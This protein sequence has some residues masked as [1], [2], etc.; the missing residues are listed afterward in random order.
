MKKKINTTTTTTQTTEELAKRAEILYFYDSRMSNPNGD[1]NENKP[2]FDE[3]TQKIYVTEFRLK[4][5]IR[6]YLNEIMGRK[7]LLRQEL[8]ED[9][10]RELGEQSLKMLDKLAAPYIYEVDGKGGKDKKKIKKIK[11]DEL[12]ADHIDIKLFGILFAVGEVQF[13]QVGPVQFVMGQSLNN[14]NSDS[15]IIPISMTAL[16]PNTKNEAGLSKG[17]SFGEKWIV[18][19]AFIQ[20]HGFV[21]NNAAKEVNLTESDVNTMLKAMWNGTDALV[22]T[23]KFGQ[24]S[25]LLV[26]VNYK[27]NGYIGDLDLMAKL[28]SKAQPLENITQMKLNLDNLFE[29]LENNIDIIESVEYE[30]NPVLVCTHNGKQGDFDKL[31]N[32]WSKQSKIPVER[33]EPDFRGSEERIEV[34]GEETIEEASD[35]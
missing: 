22:T 4:R 17:G 15:D 27:N 24:K 26:K 18:R 5:T 7:I 10:E 12:L 21:N 1:P 29:L 28:E 30:F 8:D 32:E 31:V 3:E 6:K 14:I 16:V 20:H 33:L 25:R 13:K 34:L 19:Y 11:Q 2:R 9:L 23:S 35:V